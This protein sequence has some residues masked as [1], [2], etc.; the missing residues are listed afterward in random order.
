MRRIA[1][2]HIAAWPRDGA[3]KLAPRLQA[4]TLDVVLRVI[5]GVREH[6]VA[7]D[8]L[9]RRLRRMME[10]MMGGPSLLALLAL[11]PRRSDE[12]GVYRPIL[13]PVDKL[14]HEQ[15][16]ARRADPGDDVL[17]LL[18]AARATRT[19]AR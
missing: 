14:L 12:L 6:D 3:V 15:I 13:R 16:E 17:S 7:L 5:F 4:I 18:L 8:E 1:R 9:R 19:A 2:E 10:G 11:G